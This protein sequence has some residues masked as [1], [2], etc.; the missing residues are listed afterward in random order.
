MVAAEERESPIEIRDDIPAS[1]RTYGR[2]LGGRDN[3][4]VDRD[5]TS[6]TAPAFPEPTDAGEL[7]Q[8]AAASRMR[9]DVREHGGVLRKP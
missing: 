7:V 6:K 5:F 1:A 9:R 4:R 3:Y 8:F 2:A